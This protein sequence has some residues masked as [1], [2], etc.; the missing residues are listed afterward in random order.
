MRKDELVEMMSIWINTKTLSNDTIANACAYVAELYHTKQL[1]LLGV[2][3]S[4]K[5]NEDPI[6]GT[7]TEK[8]F[9]VQSNHGILKIEIPYSYYRIEKWKK[10]DKVELV[11]TR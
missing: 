7:I 3:R 6:I 9:T 2:S 11:I 8:A 1:Q 10:G 5:E 4:N